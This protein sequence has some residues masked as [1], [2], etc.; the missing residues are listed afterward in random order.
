VAGVFPNNE[1]LLRLA[2]SILMDINGE[3]IAGRKYLS[4]EEE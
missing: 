2:G 4:M 3:W 1:S